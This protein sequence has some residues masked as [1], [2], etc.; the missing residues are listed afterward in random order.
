MCSNGC[1][2]SKESKQIIA[3]AGFP[4]EQVTWIYVNHD[5]IVRLM[6]AVKQVD[7]TLRLTGKA[8]VEDFNFRRVLIGKIAVTEI[9]QLFTRHGDL[10]LDRNIRRYL[11]LQG[12]RV[13]SAISETLNKP[14]ERSNFYFYNNGL[15]MLCKK[16]LHSG[17][18]GEDHHVQVEG[19]QIING[20]QTCKTI[21]RAIADLAGDSM[22]DIEKAF[23]LVRIYQLP[24]NSEE[25]V[26]SI[27]YA[28]NSQSPVDLRDL[29][30][31]DARQK[32]LE[33]DIASLKNA[34]GESFGYLRSRNDQPTNRRQIKSTRAAE[35]ILAVWRESPHQAKAQSR[36]LFSNSLYEKIFTN[37]LNGSQTVMATLLFRYAE[38]M[39]QRMDEGS[40]EWLVYASYFTAML[41]GRYLLAD[42]RIKRF[43]LHDSIVDVATKLDSNQLAE[44][45]KLSFRGSEPKLK[46]NASV[47]V[48]TA[49]S[50]WLVEDS[51]NSFTIEK[52]DSVLTVYQVFTLRH[53]NHVTFPN[54]LKTWEL[55]DEK[56]HKHAL[57][58]IEQA[59]RS[60]YVEH[61]LPLQKLAGIFRRGEILEKLCQ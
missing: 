8:I 29:R 42:M 9:A 23:V 43:E 39:R 19:L 44:L 33:T 48:L 47:R 18:Q 16:F 54:A 45:L 4:A 7:D 51:S 5:E 25:L 30:S 34:D 15:T 1:E 12:N 36:D 35:A 22:I 50:K 27:T 53:L 2:W 11:G 40:P 60:E 49:G 52:H 37:D 26:R 20:G 24:E 31:N 13:N 32:A 28:T 58:D 38:K 41:M 57:N 61:P 21:Q 59:L 3:N 55:N 17:L 10:L 6:Q 46:E 14:E 56:Y